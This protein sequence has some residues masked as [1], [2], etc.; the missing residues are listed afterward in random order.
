[1]SRAVESASGAADRRPAP[2]ADSPNVGYVLKVF[3]RVSETFVINEVRALEAHGENPVV[4]SLHHNPAGNVTHGIL[5]ELKAPVVYIEDELPA[6]EIVGKTRKRLA[7]RLKVGEE[8]RDRILP[9]KYVRLAL[10]LAGEVEARGIDHLHAHFASRAAHVAA[11]ASELAGCSYSMT[12]HAKDIYHEDVDQDVLRWKIQRA[13]FVVTVTDYNLR[14]LRKLVGPNSKDADK[15]VRLYNGVDLER[16]RVTEIPRREPPLVVGVGRLVEKKGF[17]LLIDACR[18][19]V[20][21]GVS[22]QC[23]LIGDGAE[24][25]ALVARVRDL[26]LEEV[27]RFRG[28]L[29]TEEVGERLHD[30]S[31]VVLPC[32]VA[33]DGNVDALPTVL[34]EAMACGRPVISTALSGIPEI[35]VD[36]ET[37]R[38]VE[39]GRVEP[40]ADAVA[41][42]LSDHER[43]AAM[44]RA[45]RRRVEQLFD[46]HANA[47]RIR[48][49]F[50]KRGPIA[51]G[52]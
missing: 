34:L 47:G 9:R 42:V 27:V 11:L 8:M 13:A 21:R 37:G 22:L 46:L 52:V 49:M 17:H 7:K 19:L 26:E 29:T 31:V 33:R 40:F 28:A 3:P 38:L 36:G 18:V 12:A 39:P 32:I 24:R 48:D 35:I 20:D 25:E 45:G 23:E 1:M 30:A 4:F 16:F 2:A 41:E 50:V 51:E 15:I 44:G 43:A 5:G 14:H 6:E 10:A